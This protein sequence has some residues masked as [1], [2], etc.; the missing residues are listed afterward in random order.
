MMPRWTTAR[1]VSGG[2][3]LRSRWVSPIFSPL[4]EK[5][6]MEASWEEIER[7][8]REGFRKLGLKFEENLWVWME[9][10]K[11]IEDEKNE[12]DVVVDGVAAQNAIVSVH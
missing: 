7:G 10:E 4:N 3:F 12:S 11:K 9:D 1:A 2:A 6:G 5:I 8:L